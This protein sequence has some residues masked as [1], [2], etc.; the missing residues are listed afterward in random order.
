MIVQMKRFREC[1]ESLL[2]R[3]AYEDIFG[4]CDGKHCGGGPCRVQKDKSSSVEDKSLHDLLREQEEKLGC[5]IVATSG[6]FILFGKE[7]LDE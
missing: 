7:Y 3:E 6:D 4:P 5:R 2:D 1:E